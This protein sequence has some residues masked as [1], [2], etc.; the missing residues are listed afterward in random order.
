MVF[1]IS[2]ARASLVFSL[3]SLRLGVGGEVVGLFGRRIFCVEGEALAWSQLIYSTV[4]GRVRL[5]Y[6]IL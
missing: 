5:Q 1:S 2:L 4:R 3:G 6:D